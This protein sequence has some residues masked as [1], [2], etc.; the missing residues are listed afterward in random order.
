MLEPQG[1]S[2]LIEG[3]V[4]V[5]DLGGEALYRVR[6]G[7]GYPDNDQIGAWHSSGERTRKTGCSRTSGPS[8]LAR[9]NGID[10][11][12]SA[13][14]AIDRSTGMAWLYRW[15]AARPSRVIPV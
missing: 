1:S 10:D 8:K 4:F 3:P 12:A 14:I 13:Q 15:K 2:R 7:S 11:S 5:A 6:G 9:R